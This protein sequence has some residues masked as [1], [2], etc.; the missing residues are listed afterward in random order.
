[1]EASSVGLYG[2]L[3]ILE[4]KAD[5]EDVWFFKIAVISEELSKV[6]GRSLQFFYL[7]I[8]GFRVNE[9]DSFPTRFP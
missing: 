2:V 7:S 5:I 4:L 6:L 1:M 3:E 9:W 8:V